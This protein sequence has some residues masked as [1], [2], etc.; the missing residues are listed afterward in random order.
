MTK[1]LSIVAAFS[2][3]TL[4]YADQ[5]TVASAAT[6]IAV[7]G[8]VASSALGSVSNWVSGA[9]Y[10]AGDIIKSKGSPYVCRYGGTGTSTNE[11]ALFN[12]RMTA[13]DGAVTWVKTTVGDRTA[14]VIQKVSGTGSAIVNFANG[15]VVLTTDLASIALTET[16]VYQGNITVTASGG[17]VVINTLWY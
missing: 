10:S 4:S 12:G 9:A 11:G 7:P 8:V 6:V 14:V 5:F 16:A 13:T 17:N 1:L 2:L 3:A 15:S